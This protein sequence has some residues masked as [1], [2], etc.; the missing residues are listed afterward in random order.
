MNIRVEDI[1]IRHNLR[2]GDL[3][4]VIYLHGLLYGKE[5]G[6]GVQFETYVAEG[7]DEFY[8]CYNETKDRVWVC[9]HD[10]K[11]VGFMLLMHR[12]RGVAQL[13]YFLVVPEYR[14]IGLGKHL[15]G[16]FI[17]FLRERQYKSAYL[18]TTNEL[19]AAALLYK[20]NGFV[21]TEEK[22]STLFGKALCEQRYD[23]VL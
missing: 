23:L 15:M 19:S 4:Y 9:E 13:R 22:P 7:I 2:P 6:F 21:L 8:R 16:L 17:E 12:E 14:G 1:R 11:M 3:G 18:W 20:R 5:Y 10:G